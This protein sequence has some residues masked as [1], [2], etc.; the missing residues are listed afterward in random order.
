MQRAY[1]SAMHVPIWAAQ[2]H[3]R[4]KILEV[5]H[6]AVHYRPRLETS[7]DQV[8]GQGSPFAQHYHLLHHIHLPHRHAI[9]SR[10]LLRPCET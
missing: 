3:K 6:H 2:R 7:V 9:L 8:S 10:Y 4:A 5:A 1:L